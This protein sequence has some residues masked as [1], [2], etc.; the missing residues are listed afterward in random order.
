MTSK[1]RS[2]FV[3]SLL[4]W[5]LRVGINCNQQQ[6]SPKMGMINMYSLPWVLGNHPWVG[7]SLWWIPASSTALNM[8]GKLLQFESPILAIRNS[9]GQG[10][11][12]C[13][14]PNDLC[15]VPAIVTGGKLKGLLLLNS[16]RHNHLRL[17]I[18]YIACESGLDL[19]QCLWAS[20]RAGVISTQL[21]KVVS[22]AVRP[23]IERASHHVTKTMI[24]HDN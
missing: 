5:P 22:G 4:G 12:F 24:S 3:N 16:I 2:Q 19:V 7:W 13:S 20:D 9:F 1:N 18:L 11:S 21:V 8:Y 23:R 10:T 14:F 15:G 6:A 17:T